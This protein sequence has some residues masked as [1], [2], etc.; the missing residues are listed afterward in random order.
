MLF[1]AFSNKNLQLGAKNLIAEF[2]ST[3]SRVELINK[4]AFAKAVQDKHFETF[5]VYVAALKAETYL[6]ITSN[7]N[8]Y[9]AIGQGLYQYSSSILC[10]AN[11]F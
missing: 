3:T 7:P 10:Y 9:F 1:L 2:L 4:K 5:I 6:S 11:V 8:N